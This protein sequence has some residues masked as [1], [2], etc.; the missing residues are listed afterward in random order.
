MPRKSVSNEVKWQIIGLLKDKTKTNVEIA[1]LCEVSEKCVRTTKKNYSL[2][3]NVKNLPRSGRPGKLSDKDKDWLFMQVRKTPD[4]S[5]RD[6]AK[7]FS[8]KFK[9]KRV[10]AN[11]VR[12]VI[13]DRKLGSYVATKKPLLRP[14]DLVRRRNWCKERLHWTVDDWSKVIFSDESNFE[15]INRKN[16]VIVKRYQ[17]EKYKKQFCVPRIQK[18]GGS[19]GIWGCISYKGPGQCNVYTGRMN[20]FTY[21][22][23][24][25]KHLFPSAHK[26]YGNNGKWFFQHDGATAHTANSIKKFMKRKKVKLLPWP[27][28]SPD[29][30]PIENLWSYIDSKLAKFH[31]T[32][33]A[34]LEEQLK[35]V[36]SEIPNEMIINLIKSM[37]KRVYACYKARG[38]HIKY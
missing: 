32:S 33:I 11:T 25:E 8:A 31:L 30:N 37:P 3:K 18:G 9:N 4:I 13:S 23:T 1:D 2:T 17:Y 28:R 36:W 15:V 24:I 22:E 7:M 19:V 12:K 29:L 21:K 34:E 20:Q 26:L 16:R 35:K 38:G 27:A 6:L 14:I 5:Y 10:C